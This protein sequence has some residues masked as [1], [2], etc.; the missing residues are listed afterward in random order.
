MTPQYTTDFS[1]FSF[2]FLASMIFMLL[3]WLSAKKVKIYFVWFDRRMSWTKSCSW[4]HNHRSDMLFQ[5][6]HARHA[7]IHTDPHRSTQ[8]HTDPHRSTHET[9]WLFNSCHDACAA[10]SN[11][12]ELSPRPAQ[13]RPSTPSICLRNLR[14]DW[15]VEKW[16]SLPI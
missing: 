5:W 1:I 8:I 3:T 9:S 12:S 2:C 13:E 4:R 10:I 16:K 15:Q 14:T 7:Q 6:W 11:T